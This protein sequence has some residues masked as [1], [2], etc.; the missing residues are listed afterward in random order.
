MRKSKQRQKGIALYVVIIIVLLSTLLALWGSRTALFNE[1]IVGNDADYQRTFEA[2]QAMLEDAQNDLLIESTKRNLPETKREKEKKALF[3]DDNAAAFDDYFDST[4]KDIPN[5]CSGAVCQ[6]KD[7]ICGKITGAQDFW[8]KK[9]NFENLTAKDVGARYGDFTGAKAGAT[10]NPILANTTPNYGAWYWIE[11]MKF[12]PS[13]AAG[14]KV[15]QGSTA[16][17][18]VNAKLIFRITAI[19]RGLKPNTQVVLQKTVAFPSIA[20][21]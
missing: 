20:G 3:P 10:G 6:C 12:T 2:A 19:A 5:Q 17:N 18:P 14:N 9:K 1:I 7:A 11:V 8:T 16:V 15:V 4:I 13:P 21:E